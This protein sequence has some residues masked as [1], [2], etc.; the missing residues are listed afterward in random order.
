M[1]RWLRLIYPSEF[2]RRHA[3]EIAVLLKAS[4]QPVRDHLDVVI[5][6]VRLRSENVMS[7]LPRYLAD[8][9]LAVA[10]FMFGFVVN[11]LESGLGEVARH[12]WSTAAVLLVIVA[13]SA[14][15]AVGVIDR[16]RTNRPNSTPT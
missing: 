9:A 2:A 8:V 15:A 4:P 7:Q 6:A 12:W 10:L 3:D 13:C 5:H 16:R 11:D 14:R 1:S